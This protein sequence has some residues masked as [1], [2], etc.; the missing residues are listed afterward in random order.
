MFVPPRKAFLREKISPIPFWGRRHYAL[1][2]HLLLFPKASS[3][4]SVVQTMDFQSKTT[5]L[6]TV[7]LKS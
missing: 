6:A 3:L 5:Y 1:S 4:T 2:S 7:F